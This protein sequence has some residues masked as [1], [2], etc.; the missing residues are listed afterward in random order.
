MAEILKQSKTYLVMLSQDELDVIGWALG[1]RKGF[2][3]SRLNG[4][5][6]L[7]HKLFEFFHPNRKVKGTGFVKGTWEFEGEGE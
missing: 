6:Q 1:A 2:G 3:E 7:A 5:A 4:R